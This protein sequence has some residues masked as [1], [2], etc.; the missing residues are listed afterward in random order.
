MLI[1]SAFFSGLEIAYISSN[2]ILLEIEKKQHSFL[3]GILQKITKR[4]SKFISTMLVGNNIALVVYGFFMGDLLM[5]YIA[6]DGFTGILIQTA[7]STLVILL[8]AEFLPKVFFQIYANSLLKFFALPVYFFYLLFSF[9]SEF[10]IWI[11]DLVLKLFFKTEGD[12]VQLSFS[13]IELGNFISEQMESVETDE[14]IDTE[15]QI[16]QNALD[17]SEVKSRE[18]MVPRTEIIAVDIQT[19]PKDLVKIFTDT[20]LSKILVYKS[21]IDDIVG[22]VHSFE[23]FK[24]P[25]TI[26]KIIMPVIF[27]PGTMLAKDVLN[28]LSKK[29]RGLAVIIDEYGGT[30]GILTVEDIVE[31][32]IGEIEDEHDNTA[33]IEED[34]GNGSYRFSARLEVDYLNEMYKLNLIESEHYETLGGLIVN[35][36]EEIPEQGKTVVIERFSFQILEVS[37]TKIELVELKRHSDD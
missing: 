6:L 25:E 36:T 24:K 8:T 21:S 9:I 19:S 27:V 18:A 37:N 14:E 5:R 2:K 33:L 26:E 28:I 30:S 17:F 12:M 1:L 11:S 35:F 4:P 31:E 32:L 20:G 29:G 10:V 16:F 22:Y 3:A 34:R 7:I 23:L 15:I 13:K